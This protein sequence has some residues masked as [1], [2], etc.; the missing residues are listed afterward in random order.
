MIWYKQRQSK[1]NA[2]SSIYNGIS[3]HSKKEAAYAQE[4]DLRKEAGDIK[5]WER[6]VAIDL[7]VHDK[8]ICRYYVDFRVIYPDGQE[9]LV[10]VK[11]FETEV[12]R[13][14]WK[15]LEAIWNKEHP[16]VQLTVV[17]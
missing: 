1:Y 5:R 16:E 6:Q 10:E 15:L 9:E 3:Y 8:K 4:L 11:G 14:K 2:K 13:L 12:W 7:F 17:K